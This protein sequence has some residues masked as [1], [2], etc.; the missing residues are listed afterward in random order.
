MWATESNENVT[1]FIKNL[2][3]YSW[4]LFDDVQQHGKE[5]QKEW[6]VTCFIHLNFETHTFYLTSIQQNF[7][8]SFQNEK[9]FRHISKLIIFNTLFVCSKIVSMFDLVNHFHGLHASASVSQ[10]LCNSKQIATIDKC[11]QLQIRTQTLFLRWAAGRMRCKGKNLKS[12][13]LV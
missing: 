2:Y 6:M 10:R 3:W 8:P 1:L 7:L 9:G 4:C 12:V 13:Y 5:K 11:A